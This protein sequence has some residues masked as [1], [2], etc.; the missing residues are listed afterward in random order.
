MKTNNKREIANTEMR[1]LRGNLGV[2][3]L[4]HIRNE[5]IIRLLNL[6]PIDET[7]RSGRL[8]WFGH[9]QGRENNVVRSVTTLALPGVGRWGC[10]GRRGDSRPART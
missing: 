8:R 4:A 1:V 6:P 3:R 2:S 5:E 10:R 7:M 9:V